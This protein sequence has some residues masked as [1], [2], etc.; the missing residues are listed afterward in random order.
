M[1]SDGHDL[2]LIQHE[3]S[4]TE[5]NEQP[6]HERLYVFRIQALWKRS[7]SRPEY[8]QKCLM[9]PV[10]VRLGSCSVV[11]LLLTHITTPVL[12]VSSPVSQH[13][14]LRI[15]RLPTTRHEGE[16]VVQ[17]IARPPVPTSLVS[18]L[19]LEPSVDIEVQYQRS[20]VR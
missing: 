14:P 16:Q 8:A 19:S 6:R 1:L 10:E 11:D 4:K 2:L 12:L 18:R 20:V 17:R 7:F 3:V 5:S 13:V 15:T 9:Q